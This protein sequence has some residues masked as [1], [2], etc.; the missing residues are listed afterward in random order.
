MRLVVF[1]LIGLVAAAVPAAAQAPEAPPVTDAMLQDPAPGDWLMWRRT[2]NGWGYS[3]LD[4]IDRENVDRLRLVWTRGLSSG[5]QEGT[6]LVYG[7]T[8][9]MPNPN[10]HLQAIDAATGDLL[11]EYRRETPAGAAETLA[12][13]AGL[14]S[15]NRN[16][17]IYGNAIIDTGNDGYVYAVD[18]ATGELA[19]ETEIFD[20]ATGAARHSSGPIVANGKVV[21]GRSCRPAGGPAACVI[22]AHDATTGAELWRT[23]LVPAPGEPGDETW[24][25][26]PY[27]E[28]VHV[29]SW[30]VPSYDPELNLVYVGTSVTSP[31]PKFLLGGSGNK[32]L[33][34]NSTLALDADTGE[35]RWYY[36]HLNDHWDMDHPFERLLVD[37]AV[38]PDPD[39][40]SWIN[41][42][43]RAGEVR[44]VVTGIPARRAWCTPSTA[45]PGSSCGPRRRSARTSSATSTAP[46]ARSARTPRSSSAR[47]GSR[48]CRARGGWAARTGKRARTAR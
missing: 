22:V 28:R 5:Y 44:R 8:L 47:T 34:H 17:A 23:R 9:Y 36:Q 42:R 13:A 31:A 7:G 48:S 38:A 24:G 4:Q 33:Y 18:A 21:S 30:M 14:V 15:V 26:V 10:D 12:A 16:V 37:T 19:W 27:E 20:Y 6:P 39:A 46:P 2:L 40:V 3:P 11:W 29:G 32:H 25:G 45:R 1:T 41:P 35:I 43:L